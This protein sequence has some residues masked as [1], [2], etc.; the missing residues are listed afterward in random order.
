MM[1]LY[2][3]ELDGMYSSSGSMVVAASSDEEAQKLAEAQLKQDTDEL[4]VDEVRLLNV[5]IAGNTPAGVI[6]KTY[7]IE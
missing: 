7:A 4:S 5:V 2:F 3:V 1:N 6:A